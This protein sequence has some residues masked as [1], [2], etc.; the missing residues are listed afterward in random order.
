MEKI[1]KQIANIK[2]YEKPYSPPPS[3]G[4]LVSSMYNLS[5]AR[6]LVYDVQKDQL[7]LNQFYQNISPYNDIVKKVF[8]KYGLTT[9]LLICNTNKDEEY[10]SKILSEIQENIDNS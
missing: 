1:K 5:R 2:P 4:G 10:M 6:E 7:I 8:N 3:G 9:S